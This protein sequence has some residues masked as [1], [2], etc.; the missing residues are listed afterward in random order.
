MGDII[1]TEGPD[2][3]WKSMKVKVLE[4]K[5]RYLETELTALREESELILAITEER[6]DAYF[7]YQSS[8]HQMP[9]WLDEH[10][11]DSPMYDVT[12]NSV[13]E[14]VCLLD[15]IKTPPESKKAYLNNELS[16]YFG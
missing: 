16:E 1:R 13:L 12:E 5:V 6:L 7:R 15:W 11:D 4:D 14:N 9:E 10:Y 2:Y 8:I 3:L